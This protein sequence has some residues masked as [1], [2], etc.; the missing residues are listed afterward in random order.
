M[1]IKYTT[2][3][4]TQ[5]IKKELYN[6]YNNKCPL[7]QE[8]L[9][10]EKIVADHQHKL[11]TEACTNWNEGGKG[12]I[13]GAISFD[14]NAI[15]GKITNAWS[16]YGMNKYDISLPDFLRNLADYLECPPAK[17][18]DMSYAYYTETPKRRK[19]KISDYK[20]VC[21]YYFVLYPNRRSLP[22]KPVYEN[23]EWLELLNS[24]LLHIQKL[25][26]HKEER[27]RIRLENAKSN[28]ETK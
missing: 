10:L 20:R 12:L 11:K 23:E 22:K 17:Q 16:R 15:E 5:D 6:I 28:K 25:K 27:K 8:N 24:T 18:C 14:A 19:V 3:K 2:Q 4:E 21:K 7:L 9:P 13:R 26:D 1:E